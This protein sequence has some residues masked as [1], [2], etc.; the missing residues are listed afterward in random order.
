M[1]K[2]RVNTKIVGKDMHRIPVD[3]RKALTSA[4]LARAT[5]KSI[6]QV[7]RSDWICWIIS[8]KKSQ[9][10]IIRIKKACNMLASGKRRVCCFAGCN[11][12]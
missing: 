1:A 2:S 4:T 9:T 8:S 7:A 11:H 12:R 5:W 3:L 6:T 10:R